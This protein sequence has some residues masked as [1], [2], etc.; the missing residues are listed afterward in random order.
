MDKDKRPV[1]A[2]DSLWLEMDTQN[3]PM[4]IEGVLWFK[5][6]VDWDR[7]R[8]LLESRVVNRYP[9]F[10]QLPVKSYNPFS[11][12][13]TGVPTGITPGLD[14]AN[15]PDFD[16]DQHIVRA[17]LPEP[18]GDAELQDYLSELMSHSLDR[19]RSL[20][21]VHFVDGF[22]DGSAVITR[23]HHA[24]AD[25]VAL[26]RV[27]LELTDADQDA[28]LRDKYVIEP[29]KKALVTRATTKTVGSL[30]KATRTSAGLVKKAMTKDGIIEAADNTAMALAIALKLLTI[31]SNDSALSGKA[32]SRKMAAWTSPIEVDELRD[33]A[34]AFEATV[35]DLL[36]ACLAGALRRYLMARGEDPQ[37]LAT[38]VPINLRPLDKPLPAE[39]GNKFALVLVRLQASGADPAARLEATKRAMDTIKASPEAYI[40]YGIIEASGALHPKIAKRIVD[41]FAGKVIGVTTN[42]PGPREPRW[43]AGTRVEGV[44]GWA[45]GARDQALMTCFFSFDGKIRAGF[46]ADAAIVDNPAEFAH[47][48]EQ[49]LQAFRDLVPHQ[50]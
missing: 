49:E 3:N 20:W 30:A 27:L 13:T 28:D 46:K 23:F 37:N 50:D 38:M 22:K 47:G 9:V 21:E 45:P 2:V 4:T 5:E 26:A 18:G 10:S 32:Q 1:S 16:L 12:A 33:V 31:D 19:K 6:Q 40:T 34:H 14:W 48:F 43:F 39:L 24:L 42:V 8:D 35:N 44:L 29:K 41:F 25:G 7:A 36:L 17:T 11:T 15:D